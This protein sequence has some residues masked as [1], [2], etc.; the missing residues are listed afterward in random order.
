[1]WRCEISLHHLAGSAKT[2]MYCD[3]LLNG[4]SGCGRWVDSQQIIESVFYELN[5]KTLLSF[6]S[7]AAVR[8]KRKLLIVSNIQYNI[9]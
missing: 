6:V 9:I 7:V 3:T 4:S 2:M 1:M 5:A 8:L